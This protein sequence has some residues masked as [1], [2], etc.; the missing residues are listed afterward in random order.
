[1]SPSNKRE[2]R[3]V[4][5]G[6]CVE[7]VAIGTRHYSGKQ[8]KLALTGKSDP[9][10]LKQHGSRLGRLGKLQWKSIRSSLPP[11]HHGIKIFP[12]DEQEQRG[13]TVQTGP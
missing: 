6:R 3:A 4:A 12:D 11:S 1:M 9:D 10:T 7:H 5:R 13:C 8:T 2:G